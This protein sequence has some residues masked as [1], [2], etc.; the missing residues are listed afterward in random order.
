MLVP[1]KTPGPPPHWHEMH[2]ETFYITEGTIRFHIPDTSIG[3]AGNDKKIVD[4]KVGDYMVVP[5]RA[6]HTFSNPSD[7]ES[8]VL[9]PARQL[10]MRIISNC[11]RSWPILISRC[12]LR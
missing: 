2:D 12:P 8:S 1:P 4:C 7:E 11:C 5:A 6:P 9:L 3:Q 10:F